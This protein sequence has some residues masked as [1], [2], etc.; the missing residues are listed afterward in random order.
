MKTK[1]N[2]DIKRYLQLIIIK[3]KTYF[4]C[5]FFSALLGNLSIALLAIVTRNLLDSSVKSNESQFISAIYFGVIILVMQI[6]A[7]RLIYIGSLSMRDI[8]HQL[9][10]KMF[11]QVQNL[12][13]R[14]FDTHHSGQSIHRLNNAVDDFKE[15]LTMINIRF[16]HCFMAGITSIVTIIIMDWRL[17]LIMLVAGFI[18]VRVTTFLSKPQ[19]EIG[20]AVQKH[21]AGLSAKLSDILAG[22]REVKM[23][24]SGET[25]IERYSK[26]NSELYTN[27]IK[28]AKRSAIVQCSNEFFN[29]LINI[30]MVIIGIIMAMYGYVTIG[31]VVGIIGLQGRLKWVLFSFGKL[32]ASLLGS[33]ATVDIIHEILDEQKEP[34]SYKMSSE[35]SKSMIEFKN[36][37]FS[38]NGD[39]E[40]IKSLSF[41]VN[42]G[43]SVALTGESGSGKSTIVKLLLGYYPVS[44]GVIIIDSKS[45]GDYSLTEL[46]SKIAYVPQ[47]AFLFDGTISENIQYGNQEA[48]EQD[49]KN[50]SIAAN[51]HQFIIKLKDGYDTIVGERGNQLSGGQRQR[52]AIA[53]AVI[54]GAPI[55]LLDEATSALDY[56]SEQLI[57]QALRELMRKS[58]NLI[59]AHRES[60]IKDADRILNMENGSLNYHEL[61]K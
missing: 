47:N 40:T 24:R 30:G 61:L 53:R 29:F 44:S 50:A 9:R 56:E 41:Y 55:L 45:I 35:S 60:T 10:L 1:R 21:T 34:T 28:S 33:F 43:E 58:T 18:S 12:P 19:R 13:I 6:I 17:G 20:K 42:K 48:T 25:I 15:A 7:N 26:E 57:Q 27:V 52:I 51:A 5:L 32:W 39:E 11:D 36:V 31:T 2:I 8:M 4:S 14:Y 49:I 3:K 46:R 23:F 37:N 59:I 16:V 54:K 38:Y 22:F